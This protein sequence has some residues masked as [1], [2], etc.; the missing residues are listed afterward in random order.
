MMGNDER[1]I[2]KV[3]QTS[4]DTSEIKSE[5]KSEMK[6]NRNEKIAFED[7]LRWKGK[8][9]VRWGK[10]S[11]RIW[12]SIFFKGGRCERRGKRRWGWKACYFGAMG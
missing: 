7:W 10:Y 1:P 12:F 9:F 6:T 3:R 11:G 8:P 4:S 5:I 2:L